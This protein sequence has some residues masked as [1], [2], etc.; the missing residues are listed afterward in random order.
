MQENLNWTQSDKGAI[1][2]SAIIVSNH[3]QIEGRSGLKEATHV[4]RP[5][6]SIFIPVWHSTGEKKAAAAPGVR[7]V[8]ITWKM[9]RPDL[10]CCEQ[11]NWEL[12]LGGCMGNYSCLGGGGWKGG[13]PCH[14]LLSIVYRLLYSDTKIASSALNEGKSRQLFPW[15]NCQ[16]GK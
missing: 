6:A 14:L 9:T 10:G 16:K 7:M 15:W 13:K 8:K 1:K 5:S 3:L 12:G 4:C 2:Q 11:L